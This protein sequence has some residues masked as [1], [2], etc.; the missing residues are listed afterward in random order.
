MFHQLESRI[1]LAADLVD[2]VLRITHGSGDDEVLVYVRN[3]RMIVEANG[4]FEDVPAREVSSVFVS[5]GSGRDYVDL[6]QLSVPSEVVLGSSKDTLFGT[7]REDSVFG[8]NGGDRIVT[9]GGNDFIDGGRGRDIMRGGAGVDTIDYSGRVNAVRVTTDRRRD[10][11]ENGEGDM[12]TA[13]IENVLG[14]SGDD[15]L[16]TGSAGGLADGGE[17]DDTLL[18]G[19]GRDTLDGGNGDDVIR[20][21]PNRDSMVGGEGNDTADYSERSTNLQITLDGNPNDGA[22]NERDNVGEDFET[23]LGGSGNDSIAGTDVTDTDPD[24]GEPLDGHNLLVG[25][26]GNDLILGLGGHDTLLGFNGNDQLI[27]GD[28]DDFVDGG[29]GNDQITGDAGDDILR[30]G[31]GLDT[32]NGGGGLDFADYSDRSAP[33]RITLDGIANDGETNERENVPANVEGVLGGSGPD[34]ITGGAGGNFIDGGRGNDLLRGEDGDDTIMPGLGRD[35]MFGGDGEDIA[36]Y[37][38]RTRSVRADIDGVADDGEEGEGDNVRSDFEG[39]IGGAGN[40]TLTGTD[41]V[42]DPDTNLPVGGDNY[43]EGGDGHDIINGLGGDDTIRPGLGRDDINGGDGIDIADYGDREVAVVVSRD[44]VA[45]DGEPDEQDNV[46]SDMEGFAGGTSDDTIVGTEGPDYLDGGGGNDSIDG[47]G[48]DDT[49]LGGLGND[50]LNGGGGNDTVEYSDHVTN[51]NIN[52]N[53][54]RAT[55]TAELDLLSNFENATGGAGN[56]RI[57][58]SSSANTLQGGDGNDTINGLDGA[59]ILVGNDGDDEFTMG[60]APDGADTLYGGD[61]PV[62]PTPPEEGAGGFDTADYSGRT[63]AVSLSL[64]GAANDGEAGENDLIFGDID[65]LLGGEGDDTL[66]GDQFANELIGNEGNDSLEGFEGDDT[67]R[68]ND[69]DDTLLAGDGADEVWGG[70]GIDTIETFGDGAV[71]T[72]S[73]EEDQDVLNVDG[74]EVTDD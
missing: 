15:L 51:V 25:N 39:L 43:L 31:A 16:M 20:G 23:V 59:D 26:A 19:A 66:T 50:T 9:R 33:L 29:A 1:L 8:G 6:S 69:G 57:T 60:G 74:T 40:D 49:I 67:L 58:G 68:G 18:G 35:T 56:D 36:D 63:E 48:G 42:I 65:R 32:Y 70:Q 21:G 55:S 45:N 10:D 44:D 17:G 47:L 54:G 53:T 14:G 38:D 2:G 64:D 28:E 62:D 71:D 73:G 7:S 61:I 52:L 22:S 5:T 27:G 11:G 41:P 24:T 34:T 46:H 37:S 12:V 72:G 13:D 3:A 4:T 30:G